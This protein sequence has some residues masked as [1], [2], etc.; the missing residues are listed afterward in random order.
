VKELLIFLHANAL[1]INTENTVAVSF[2]TEQ[3][4]RILKPQITYN[5][6]D[7]KYKYEIKLSVLHV[8][9]NIK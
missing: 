8:T 5:D 1:V 4:K 6:M 3:S 7:I 9:E 2:H